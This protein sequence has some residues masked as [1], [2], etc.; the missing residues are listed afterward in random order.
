MSFSAARSLATFAFGVVLARLL[1]PEPFGVMAVALAIVAIG[2][3]VVEAGTGS[4]LVQVKSLEPGHIASALSLQ[5][6]LGAAFTVTVLS[7]ATAIGGFFGMPQLTPVLQVL[8]P[9]FLIQASGIVSM[10]LLRRELKQSVIA[11]FQFLAY[12]ASA[13][14]VGI[15]LAIAGAGVWSLVASQ[16]VFATGVAASAIFLGR[17]SWRL[18]WPWREVQLLRYGAMVLLVGLTNS[19]VDNVDRLVAGRRLGPTD[20]GLYSRAYLT[21]RTGVDGV[22]SAVSSPLFSAFSKRQDETVASARAFVA[23]LNLISLVLLPALVLLA[24]LASSVVRVI[25]GEAWS[26]MAPALAILSVAMIPHLAT[27]VSSPLLWA[28]DRVK[29]ELIS[30]ALCLGVLCAGLALAGKSITAIGA[31]VAVAY[32]VRA[33]LM[34]RFAALTVGVAWGRALHAWLAGSRLAGAVALTGLLADHLLNP[35]GAVL[36]GGGAGLALVLGGI[37]FGGRFE[38]TDELRQSADV[39]GRSSRMLGLRP[40]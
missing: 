14:V 13:V 24:V 8:S 12:V 25:Y 2:Q 1:G 29:L 30:S 3:L 17:H 31:A 22:V 27:F 11:A 35:L 32:A 33:L 23:A 19:I 5:L 21:A 16:L 28:R 39:L 6:L 38:I 18:S 15:P 4:A 40:S 37:R 10:S 9:V 26:A 34:T 20:T 36:V 7:A